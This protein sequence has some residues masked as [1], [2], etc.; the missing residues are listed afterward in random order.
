MNIEFKAHCDDSE[1]VDAVV[2]A[3]GGVLIRDH[4]EE[5]TYFTAE[6]A[7]LKLRRSSARVPRLITYVRSDEQKE[8]KSDFEIA[9]F[10][11]GSAGLTEQVLSREIGIKCKVSKRRKTYEGPGWL[12]NLDEFRGH[13]FVEVEIDTQTVP[14][15]EARVLASDMREAFGVKKIDILS[16]SYEQ[17]GRILDRAEGYRDRFGDRLHDLVLIDGP[18]GAGKSTMVSRLR[19]DLSDDQFRFIRRCTSRMRRPGDEIIDEYEYLSSVDFALQA[20]NGDF[21]EYRD[22]L[23]G[24]SYGVRWR[25]VYDALTASSVR[26]AFALVNLGNARHIR[27]FIPEARLVLISAPIDDLRARIEARG[28]HDLDAVEERLD[29]ARMADEG[30]DLYDQIIWNTNGDVESAYTQL[31]HA[32]EGV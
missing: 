20:D 10:T 24:M 16:Q 17:L 6:S 15:D 28:L 3:R 13:S 5:D 14:L 7:R 8:R 31:R 30:L 21:V 23:F 26:K 25:D 1:H 9:E 27:E 4:F 12:V 32:V 19:Q 11:S 18:S 2:R 29:N 22:F